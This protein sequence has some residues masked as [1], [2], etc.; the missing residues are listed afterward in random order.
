MFFIC[1]LV[2][3]WYISIFFRSVKIDSNNKSL[4]SI[5]FPEK[6]QLIPKVE[7]IDVDFIKK[8]EFENIDECFVVP[9]KAFKD[10]VSVKN[11]FYENMEIEKC[12]STNVWNNILNIFFVFLYRS[13][14][15]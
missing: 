5:P 4:D 7:P 13:F 10:K 1:V 2:Q 3:N 15:W 8:E 6:D 9:G 11:K 12:S 14:E